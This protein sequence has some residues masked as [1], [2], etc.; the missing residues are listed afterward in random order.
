MRHIVLTMM[1]TMVTGFGWA[2]DE[3][4]RILGLWA[5]DPEGEGGQAHIEVS[6]NDGKYCGTIVWLAEPVYAADDEQGMGGQAKVDREN[7]DPDLKSR[8]IQGMV[9]FEGFTYAGKD[10]W[11]EGT[12]YD[13]D[14]GKTYSC[15]LRLTKKGLKVRG[16]IGISLIG[17]TSFWTRVPSGQEDSQT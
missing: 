11:K 17:R 2:G 5:T 16:F 3:G 14:N 13:P 15:T 12:I 10:K 4:D 6:L 9:T 8:S 1:L 7:P